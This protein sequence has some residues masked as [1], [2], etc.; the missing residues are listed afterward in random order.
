MLPLGIQ[1]INIYILV[2]VREMKADS[3]QVTNSGSLLVT[4]CVHTHKAGPMRRRVCTRLDDLT[5]NHLRELPSEWA[6]SSVTSFLLS[7]ISW[8]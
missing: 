2:P 1:L 3:E 8:P 6:V 5:Q 4:T 7:Q